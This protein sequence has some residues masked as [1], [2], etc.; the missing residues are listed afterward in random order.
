[1]VMRGITLVPRHGTPVLVRRVAR[2]GAGRAA[3][4][5]TLP[6]RLENNAGT[7]RSGGAGIRTRIHGFGDRAHSR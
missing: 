3:D 5:A 1:V 7:A 6:L 4:R 2:A